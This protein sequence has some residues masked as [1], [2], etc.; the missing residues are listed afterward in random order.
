VADRQRITPKI[1]GSQPQEKAMSDDVDASPLDRVVM[2]SVFQRLVV[3]EFRQI[4]EQANEANRAHATNFT[5]L[6]IALLEKG[7]ISSEE[8]DAARIRATSLVD[9]EFARKRDER[10]AEVDRRLAEQ[11]GEILG[12]RKA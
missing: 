7:I 5:T 10:R 9:Q 12:P 2:P 1:S 4:V 3:D 8:M 11:I 6:M